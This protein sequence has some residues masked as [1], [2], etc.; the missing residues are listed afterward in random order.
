MAT[1]N[2]RDGKILND[3]TIE[4]LAR[5]AVIQANAGCDIVTFEQV[6]GRVK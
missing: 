2:L 1:M 3:E 4:I 6:D 5:Q